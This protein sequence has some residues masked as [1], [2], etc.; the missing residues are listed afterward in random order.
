M[1]YR[2]GCRGRERRRRRRGAEHLHDTILCQSDQIPDRLDGLAIRL[3]FPFTMMEL[4]KPGNLFAP[5]AL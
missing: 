4:R 5:C 2:Q 3:R 1:R